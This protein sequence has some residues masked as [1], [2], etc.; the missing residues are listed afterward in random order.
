[1]AN[2]DDYLNEE[3]GSLPEAPASVT[4]S[5]IT[6]NGFDVLFTLRAHSDVELVEL[7]GS[8]EGHF[9]D[10]GYSS[11]GRGGK[12]SRTYSGGSRTYEKPKSRY[13]KPKSYNQ[14]S[15]SY[16][17]SEPWSNLPATPKQKEVLVDMGL[18]QEGMSKQEASD[19]L[20]EKLGK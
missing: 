11:Q 17:K 15:D 7:M 20:S 4:Y 8:I 1:M 18:W 16:D 10:Q 14:G 2:I 9:L 19:V 6:P 13:E 3:L 12:S 5:L